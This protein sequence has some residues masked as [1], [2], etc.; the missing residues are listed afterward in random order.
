MCI[1][2]SCQPVPGDDVIGYITRGRGVSIHRTDCPNI[3]ELS[4]ERR[5]DIDLVPSKGDS[6][7][8]DLHMEC[9]DRMGLLT[10]VAKAIGD[11]GTN[12]KQS[13][14]QSS[15]MGVFGQFSVEVESLT[16]LKRVLKSIGNV[17]GV[18][19]VKRLDDQ[20]KLTRSK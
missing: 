16:E 10:D 1:R 15:E 13:T 20:S 9:T 2:D 12:I 18:T 17:D 3:L 14:M 5:V 11:V 8:V 7:F 6:F 19:E 4:D